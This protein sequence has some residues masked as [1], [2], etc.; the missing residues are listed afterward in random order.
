MLIGLHPL[1]TGALLHHLDDMGHGDLVLVCDAHFPAARVVGRVLEMPGTHPAELVS[2][3]RTVFPLDDAQPATFME[4]G[5][6]DA[7]ALRELRTACAV[8]DTLA[9]TLGR[10]D[11]YTAAAEAVFAVRTGERRVFG[12]ALLRKGVA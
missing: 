3:I 1:L 10:H 11:F 7:P 8:D 4:P 6:V 9:Q 12:N 5:A 2:A